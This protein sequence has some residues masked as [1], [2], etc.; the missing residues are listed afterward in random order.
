[1][2]ESLLEDPILKHLSP[3]FRIGSSSDGDAVTEM[4]YGCLWYD[5]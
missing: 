4:L 3:C 2:R 1:M 5:E